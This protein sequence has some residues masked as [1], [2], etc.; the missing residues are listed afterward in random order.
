MPQPPIAARHPHTTEHFGQRR[1]DDYFWLRQRD[2]PEVIAYLEA[3]NAYTEAVMAH[4]QPLQETLYQEFLSRIK[5]TDLSVPVRRDDYYYYSRTEQGRDYPIFCRKHG[6]L[7]APEEAILDVNVLAKG[8]D[9]YDI[10]AA[11]ISPDHKLLAYGEDTDG[12]ETYRLRIKNLETGELLGVDIGNTAA[13][14]EWCL[15]SRSFYYTVLDA[16][17]RPYRVLRHHLDGRPEEQVLEE[18]DEAFFVRLS[19]SKDRRQIYISLGSHVT[20]EEYFLDAADPG[21]KPI[22][23]K[24]R[25]HGVEYSIDHREGELW[26]L[27]NK[28]AVNFRL[29]RAPVGRF[30]EASAWREYIPHRP[31]TKLEGFE[32]FRDYLVVYL[33]DQGLLKIRIFDLATD[34][35]HDIAFDE[36]VYATYGGDN[37][38]YDSRM[39]RFAYTSLVTPRRIYDYDM[40][41]RQKT[42]LKEQEVPAGHDPNAYESHRLW[43]T[44]SDGTKVPISLVHKKGVQLDRSNPCLLYG[45]GAYGISMD[46]GFSPTRLSLL[47]RGFVFAVAHIRGG[48]DLGE[49]WK[50]AGKLLEKI[51]TFTDFIAAAEHLIEQG[52]TRPERLAIMGGSAGGLLMGAVTNMRPELFHCVVAQVPFVDVLNSMQDASLPLTVIEYDEWGNP[53][54]EEYFRAIHAYSPYDN[55]TPQAYPHILIVAGLNDPRVQYWEPAK[56]CAKLRASKTDDNLLLLKTHMGAGHG[57]ASGRYEALKELAFDYAFILDRLGFSA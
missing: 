12:S 13:D 37:P 35:F 9:Y 46:P 20:S 8:H 45:Y 5:E 41:S 19:H 53:A 49:P 21:T 36:E 24:A 6:D 16:T 22:L 56:W 15:D 42:L 54:E 26:L 1:V 32:L 10:G 47:E 11:A 55:V 25:E 30:S 39:L 4:T 50:N 18:P 51:N 34:A 57:G 29:L 28:D 3:E 31:Q 48:G 2:N 40:A 14:I 43:A 23:F 27:T 52:Y 44:A 17:K 33:R 38:E 7:D